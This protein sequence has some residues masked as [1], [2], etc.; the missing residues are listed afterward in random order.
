[1]SGG[2]PFQ[3]SRWLFPE[4]FTALT[5]GF[6]Q[7]EDCHDQSR[8]LTI[9]AA[10]SAAGRP[11]QCIKNGKVKTPKKPPDLAHGGS[12]TTTSSSNLYWKD[13][14]RVDEGGGIRAELGK[15]ITEA[16]DN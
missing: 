2:R 12:D 14:R 16:V 1:M 4:P 10:P 13:L 15:E 6:G 8:T 3:R 5:L 7:E 11:C 9:A